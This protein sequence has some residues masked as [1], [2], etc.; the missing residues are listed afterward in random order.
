M[1]PAKREAA[2]PGRASGVI[3]SV[4]VVTAHIAF[5]DCSFDNRAPQL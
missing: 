1:G 2:K 5:S 4:G 3:A